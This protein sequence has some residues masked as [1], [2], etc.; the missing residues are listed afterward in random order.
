MEDDGRR[1][2]AVR[3]KHRDAVDSRNG[4]E[5]QLP[6]HSRALVPESVRAGSLGIRASRLASR[7]V[8]GDSAG[9]A[10]RRGPQLDRAH[11]GSNG[12][13]PRSPDS[14]DHGSAAQPGEVHRE[15]RRRPEVCRHYRH[16]CRVRHEHGIAGLAH[17]RPLR[18]VHV[19]GLRQRRVVQVRERYGAM[20][21]GGQHSQR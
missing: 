18:H 11:R 20:V 6:A 12:R 5:G 1:E 14:A 17:G 19:L 21:R 13:D 2:I 7:C 10:H 9:V 15:V 4:G 16:R 3:R 8:P